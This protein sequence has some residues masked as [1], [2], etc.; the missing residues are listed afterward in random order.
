M[1]ASL[2]QQTLSL[3]SRSSETRQTEERHSKLLMRATVSS[4]QTL[5]RSHQEATQTIHHLHGST[6]SGTDKAYNIIRTAHLNK[7]ETLYRTVAKNRSKGGMDGTAE[8]H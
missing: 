2:K 4:S 6:I 8:S 3:F 1:A 5:P 7:K